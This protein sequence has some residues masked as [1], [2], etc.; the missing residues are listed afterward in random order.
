MENG[1][2]ACTWCDCLMEPPLTFPHADCLSASAGDGV[3]ISGQAA[4]GSLVTIPCSE[5]PQLW[6]L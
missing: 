4:L 3:I 6:A 1:W 2:P 5:S